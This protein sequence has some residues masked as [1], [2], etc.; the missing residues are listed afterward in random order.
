M[1]YSSTSC[2]RN[3]YVLVVAAA[4]KKYEYFVMIPVTG[5]F[6]GD[7]DPLPDMDNLYYHATCVYG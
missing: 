4:P 6:N 7:K 3:G 2:N 5:L 1:Y